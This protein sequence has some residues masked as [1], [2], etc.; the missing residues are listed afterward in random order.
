MQLYLSE[1]QRLVQET[2]AA[3]FK[4]ELPSSRVRDSEFC[5]VDNDLWGGLV[6]L[7]A[8]LMRVSVDAGGSGVSL[9]DA[10][11]V[12]EEYGRAAAPV[13]L[14]EV[15][16]ATRVLAEIGHASLLDAVASGVKRISFLPQA[17]SAGQV[18]AAPAI[19]AC[20][21]MLALCDG[22][23]VLFELPE[24]V[25]M[26]ANLGSSP[27]ASWIIPDT[28][29]LVSADSNAIRIFEGGIEEWKLLTAAAII[30]ASMRSLEIACEYAVERHA[31]GKAIG[32]YQGLAHPLADSLCDIDGARLLLWRTLDAIAHQETEA[33][34][35]VSQLWWFVS[36]TGPQASQRA[37]RTL[38]GYGLT[39]EYDSQ[40]FLRRIHAWVLLN[41]DPAHELARAGKRLWHGDKSALPPVGEIGID[42]SLGVAADN[43]AAETETFFKNNLTDELQRKAHHSTAGHH[44][45]LH[46]KMA[47]AGL[48]YA[49]W[50][51]EFGGRECN[52]YEVYASRL[53]FERYHW[54]FS[55]VATTSMV[56]AMIQLFGSDQLK[57]ELLPKIKAGEVICSL[58][59]SEPSCGSDVFAAK[60]TA[61]PDG[62]TG[63]WIINGQKMFTTGAHIADYVLMLTRTDMS[64]KK[65]AGI[66][67][68]LVPLS[69]PGVEVHKVDTLMSERTNIAYFQDV[70]V[71][72]SM[73]IGD[74]NTGA[75]V[76]SRALEIEQGGADFQAPQVQML[77][78]A[79][80]WAHDEADGQRP[81]DNPDVCSRLAAVVA[82]SNVSEGLVRR[83]LWASEEEIPNKAWGPIS[84]LY[85]TE[86][87]M[88][89][90]WEL[91]QVIGSASLFKSKDALGQIELHH[92]RAY[93][94]TI[95]A[96][97]SEVHRSMIAEQRLGL[98]RTR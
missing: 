24:K 31:F 93:G 94:T 32:S 53:V 3:F 21:A 98:P 19:A 61:I 60:T 77:Q 88:T 10:V 5:G 40:L 1:E 45:E 20:D 17:V 68:F 62:I 12:A 42:F 43:F 6:E 80:A 75:K 11:L 30:G 96:G 36:Q 66:S 63:G 72:D 8:P 50:P 48:V 69:A 23:V 92:R 38:G 35:L 64:A 89:N 16:I 76:M 41:G 73:R 33:A 79:I 46:K 27:I 47:A 29:R 13:P 85:A 95:Y 57:A 44:P 4:K 86:S 39:M 37:M 28:H 87:Y 90:S 71:A 52:R 14:L 7:G 26:A 83:N 65:H 51:V 78:Q 34:S 67:L 9:L 84:K 55:M 82:R 25:A 56:A 81:I 49:D 2:F 22:Q 70:Q 91:M 58:G 54:T 15:M 74:L 59:F 18:V 97:T